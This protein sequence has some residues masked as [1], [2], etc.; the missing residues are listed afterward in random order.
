MTKP[1]LTAKNTGV[2]E[3]AI[4]DLALVE[5]LMPLKITKETVTLPNWLGGTTHLIKDLPTGRNWD[6]DECICRFVA[7]YFGAEKWY[8]KTIGYTPRSRLIEITDEEAYD[9]TLDDKKLSLRLITCLQ[10]ALDDNLHFIKSSWKSSQTKKKVLTVDDCLEQL[11]YGGVVMSFKRGCRY[12]FMREYINIE[13]EY[14]VVIYENRIRY[15]EGFNPPVEKLVSFIKTLPDIYRD[16]TIDIGEA[17]GEFFIVEINTPPYLL[18]GLTESLDL[19]IQTDE[20]KIVL[21]QW[22]ER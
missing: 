3:E 2:D 20:I 10:E 4:M 11:D 9:L 1:S 22:R 15:I 13:K 8:P 6:S 17:D 16:M 7:R 19:T 18:A 14:R 12:I 21:C 5:R